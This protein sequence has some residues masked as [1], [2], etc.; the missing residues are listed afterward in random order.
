MDSPTGLTAFPSD[1]YTA[2]WSTW[3]GDGTETVT[4]RW[5]NE[6]WTVSG[7]VGRERVEYVLRLSPMWQVRQFLL[8]RDMEEPD[9]WLATDGH[10]RWGE[11]NGAHRTELD[12]CIDIDL[13]ITP[14]TNTLPIRRLPLHVGHAAD[15]DVVYVDVETLELRRESQRYARLD[16][17]HW[18]F[19]QLS[20]GW[21]QEF[22]VDE[23]GLV[24]DYPTRFRRTL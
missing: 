3:E 14:F 21:S 4:L 1:G 6:A 24:L 22:D 15:I 2:T 20:S 19:T 9:L 17:H 23:H 5:E 11:M 7:S 12:G 16:T 13:P 8:F 10:G 18:A